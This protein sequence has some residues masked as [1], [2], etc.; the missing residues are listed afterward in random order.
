[1]TSRLEFKSNGDGKEYKVE[2]IYDSAIYARESEDH[3]LG[4]YYLVL[5]KGYHEEE[6]TWEPGLAILYL[7]KLVSA[8]HHDYL[9]KPIVTFPPIDSAPL[10][11]RPT[12]KPK[13][14]ASSIK[15]K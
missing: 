4:L 8:F 7:R 1:M 12:V 11:A 13:T 5:W 3:L 15:Q 2:V 14:E 9:E 10:M 6:N